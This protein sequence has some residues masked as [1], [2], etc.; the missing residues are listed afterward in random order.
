MTAP[1]KIHTS[2]SGYAI[3]FEA[4]FPLGAD[5]AA[6][7]FAALFPK[8][9]KVRLTTLSRQAVM[10]DGV[11]MMHVCDNG[12]AYPERVR[13]PYVTAIIK[14]VPDRTTGASNEGGIRR[15]RSILKTLAKAGYQPEWV[16]P[17][18]N[19]FLTPEAL[20]EFLASQA[21]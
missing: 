10:E 8:S 15:Y 19:A 18:S 6:A 16:V 11:P 4:E 20:E 3:R 14:I 21:G 9:T 1:R 5:A 17:F 7:E 13:V 2:A 12:E